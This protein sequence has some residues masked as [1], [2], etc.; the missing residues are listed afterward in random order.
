MGLRAEGGMGC[1]I[2]PAS[3]ITALGIF[4]RGALPFY[5]ITLTC[6]FQGRNREIS[7]LAKHKHILPCCFRLKLLLH[8]AHEHAAK[9]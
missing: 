4:D 1:S 9:M 5:L 8:R 7:L 6:D 3:G 2:T